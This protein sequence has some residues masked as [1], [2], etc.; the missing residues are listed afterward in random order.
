M[1]AADA[2]SPAL[3]PPRAPR[4]DDP[5]AERGPLHAPASAV[6]RAGALAGAV[7]LGAIVLLVLAIVLAAA[8]RPSFLSPFTRAGYFPSWMAGPL[9][10][11]L[12]SLT[13]DD[14]RLRAL[15]SGA[16]A[17]LFVSYL[18]ALRYGTRLRA[19]WV[20]ATIVAVQA[21]LLC[22]P[23]LFS[24]DVFNYLNYGRMGAVHGL[25]PY[26]TLPLLEPH[27]DPA[28]AISNWHRL[29]SPYGPLF[30]LITYALS[31]LGVAASFWAVKVIIALA[32]LGTLALLWRCAEL[33]GR[34][35]RAALVLVGLNPL[36]LVW[37]LGADHNDALMMLLVM[38]SVY[39]ALRSCRATGAPADRLAAA[40]AA[41]LVTA[42]AIKASAGIL[43]PVLVLAGR[44][45]A[46]LIGALA[47]ALVLGGASLLAF[48]AHV[49]DLT[50][51]SRLVTPLGFANVLGVLLGLGGE[52]AGLRVALEAV[53]GTTVLV[54]AAVTL[55]D[56][57]HALAA[58]YVCVLA[59][60]LTLSWSAAWY[61]LWLLPFAALL[62]GWPPRAIALLLSAFLIL[63]FAPNEPLVHRPLS[64]PLYTTSLGRAH[65][66][67][68]NAL[69][70]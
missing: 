14:A 10:G 15:S 8:E 67:E 59:L 3:V 11:L 19:R 27:T 43:L 50:T 60:V 66:S 9:A 62:R 24:T 7:A 54:A 52:T 56:P 58:A 57:R 68:I 37:G 47:A 29:L 64:L 61:I 1:A 35:R 53:L 18:L 13:R 46:K 5:D 23:P 2:G 39:L 38:L 25:N 33:L 70:R 26:T 4:R 65:T 36:V 21:I 6:A 28:F 48:G 42:I 31:P 41:A 63:A 17:L 51:Q 40:S 55:R 30:T 49:P 34:P 32:N 69:L 44:R 22:A 20:I 45:R 16:I 12:P